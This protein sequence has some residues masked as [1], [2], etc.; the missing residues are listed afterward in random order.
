MKKRFLSLLILPLIAVAVLCGCKSDKSISDVETAYNK[1]V[2]EH[3]ENGQNLFFNHETNT[4]AI[5]IYYP[6]AQLKDAINQENPST[7]NDKRFK[8]ISYQQ[9]ILD[10]IYDYYNT[11]AQDFYKRAKNK[12]LDKDTING[13]YDS[14]KDIGSQLSDFKTHY[15]SFVSVATSP[16]DTM[17]FQVMSYSYHLN[18]LIDKSFNMIHRFRDIYLECIGSDYNQYNSSNL[19]C[20]VDTAYLDMAYIVYL[21]NIKSFNYSV[22]SN[23]LCD[24]SAV[25]ASDNKYNLLDLLGNKKTISLLIT[26]NIDNTESAV[27]KEVLE[28]VDLFVYTRNIFNQRLSNYLN[29]YNNEDIYEISQYR[30][31]L[32]GGVSYD[33]YLTSLSS[34]KRATITILDEFVFDTFVNYM[35]K[36]DS[37]VEESIN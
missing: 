18:K 9:L 19:N 32:G 12:D 4:K 14:V 24:L 16:T 35:N 2:S 8:A 5:S 30:F 37:I 34:S 20:Y 33:S 11:Y 21:E 13:L 1:I 6:S 3:I 36:L 25:V 22:G 23:G 7:D 31:G 15:D 17:E 28:K 29:N 26:S 10:Y 27:G